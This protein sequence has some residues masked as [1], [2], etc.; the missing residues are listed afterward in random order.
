MGEEAVNIIRKNSILLS[1]NSPLAFVVGA[2]GFLGSHL[3]EQLL[4]KGIQVI[5]VDDFSCGK[6]INLNEAIKDRNF[7]LINGSITDSEF[8]RVELAALKLPRLDY[9]FFVAENPDLPA[10][11]SE[12]IANFLNIILAVKQDTEKDREE[13]PLERQP[14]IV[15][16][17]SIEL[18]AGNLDEQFRFLKEGEVIFAKLVKKHRLNGRI[19]RLS[20][21]FG[22]R[23]HFRGGD[24]VIRLLHAS[25]LEKL[26]SE[27]VTMDFSTRALFVDDAVDLL[28]KSV[29]AGSTAQKIYDGAQVSPI[30][31]AEIKQILL[32]PVWHEMRHFRPSELPPWL[33]PNLTKT[34]RELAWKPSTNIIEALKKTIAYFKDHDIHIPEAGDNLKRGKD[35]SFSKIEGFL[36]GSL[37]QDPA[38]VREDRQANRQPEKKELKVDRATGQNIVQSKILPLLAVLVIIYGLLW[39]AASLALGAFNIRNHLQQSKQALESGDF[40]K[41]GKEIGEANTILK[42]SKKII[43]SLAILQRLGVFND[44]LISIEEVVS[45]SQVGIDGVEQAIN[46][47]R[48]LYEATRVISGDSQAEPR[49]LYE[50][51]QAQLNLASQKI[52]QV[53][54]KLSDQNFQ[55]RLPRAL[56]G[57]SEDLLNKLDQYTDLIEKAR[58]AS[59]LMPELTAIDGKKSYLVL[60]QNNFELRPTGGFIGSYAKLSFEKGKLTNIVVDDVYNLD[61][62]LKEVIE[63]PGELKSDLGQ[64]RLYLRDSNFDPDFPTSARLAEFFFKREAG[65]M[66]NGVIALD[67]AASAALLSAVGGLDLPEYGEHVDGTNL[68]ERAI[69]RA[70]VNFFP[71]SQAKKNYL[72]SLQNQLFNKIFYL[73]K[74]NWPAIIQAVS[75]SLEQK[76]IL[77]YLSDPTLFSY[78]VSENWAGVLTRGT[79]GKQGET[80]DFLAVIEANLGANKSNYYLTRQYLLETS[81]GKEGQIFH[82]LKISYKNDSPS[83]VFPGGKYKNRLRLYLPLGV[84]LTKVSW[85]D[86]EITSSVGSF[87]DYGR[88]GYSMLLA[89]DPKEEKILTVEYNLAKPLD[90]T[91]QLAKY[92]LDI[93]K[94]P[95]TDKDRFDWSLTYP[96]NLEVESQPDQA[97]STTQEVNI[98]TDLLRDRSFMLNFKEKAR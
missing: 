90:F 54:V 44:Q 39:P 18:Y 80:K 13:K 89:L 52:A 25:L 81:L 9:A 37:S 86:K 95:G 57:R 12:G 62:N 17:S 65:E 74:Q 97:I 6:Q 23:M 33:T 41:A 77:I 93:F 67:L 10:V 78:L 94:Q 58:I 5:G 75:A 32:D 2:A 22:P 55:G 31:V 11:F 59:L 26:P 38:A 79:E 96:I 60:L 72:T 98:A 35:W 84:K 91:N 15:F 88:T 92:R 64:T 27:Q 70:E 85:G 45:L 19:V 83:E 21:L 20:A 34:V 66:V 48:L 53:K 71:G 63:P 46:G 28:I 68:F 82:K 51:A 43:A 73:S 30:K 47:T 56:Q 14:R 29:L 40:S 24:P 4:R 8:V 7:H 36:E 50:Q 3:V 69:T 42:D 1:R 87:S 49:L 16:S 61:G 76:H